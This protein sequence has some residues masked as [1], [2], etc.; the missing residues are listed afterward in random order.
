MSISEDF[1]FVS[2]ARFYGAWGADIDTNSA[3]KI[4]LKAQPWS[5]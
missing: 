4:I 1:V 3:A 2:K 5:P